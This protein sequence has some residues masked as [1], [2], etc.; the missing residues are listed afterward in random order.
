MFFSP[1]NSQ[2]A[3]TLLLELCDNT[4]NV[5]GA[6]ALIGS[7]SGEVAPSGVFWGKDLCCVRGVFFVVFWGANDLL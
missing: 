7:G 4:S 2:H 3:D 1:Q 6:K 5:A